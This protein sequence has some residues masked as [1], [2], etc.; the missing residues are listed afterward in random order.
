M[1]CRSPRSPWIVGRSGSG[2]PFDPRS[3]PGLPLHS[4][5]SS[6]Y[7]PLSTMGPPGL[8]SFHSVHAVSLA[9]LALDR[10]PLRERQAVR[11]AFSSRP[12]SPF[13]TLQSLFSTLND[14]PTWI[15]F[16]PLRPCGVAR[17]ARLGSLAAQGAAGRSTRVLIQASLSI[18]HSPVTILHSQ[19]WAHLD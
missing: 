8:T 4:P 19:R 2:R 18:P 5:L 11:P 10:W 13:P 1:R 14:G 3:H 17:P 7:S 9:P 12:P 6:H 16:V 15:D